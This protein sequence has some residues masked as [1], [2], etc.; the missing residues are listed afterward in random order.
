[1]QLPSCILN[2]TVL[3]IYL[4]FS[5]YLFICCWRSFPASL[6]IHWWYFPSPEKTCLRSSFSV[7]F[8][9]TNSV[10]V[11]FSIMLFFH[12]NSLRIFLKLY[13]NLL[14]QLFSFSR[15]NTPSCCILASISAVDVIILSNYYLKIKSTYLRQSSEW[16]KVIANEK[17]DKEL[18]SKIYKQLM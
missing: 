3:C 2:H 12:H 18:V 17:T 8:Q 4:D 11:L 14:Y 9:V 16:K 5:I 7:N 1:M 6:T 10:T 15:F 13:R